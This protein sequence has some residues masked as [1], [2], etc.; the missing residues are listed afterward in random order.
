ML[1]LVCWCCP[2]REFPHFAFLHYKYNWPPF[3][4]FL[5]PCIFSGCSEMALEPLQHQRK[6]GPQNELMLH[7]FVINWKKSTAHPIQRIVQLG[8]ERNYAPLV[9]TLGTHGSSGVE[10]LGLIAVPYPVV[11]CTWGTHTCL[12]RWLRMHY[13]NVSI[14]CWWL[15]E[16]TCCT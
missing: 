5:A 12:V 4:S 3:N 6:N 15:L 11:L 10:L 7:C 13:T 9:K 14:F 1:T 16:R 2:C 8:M